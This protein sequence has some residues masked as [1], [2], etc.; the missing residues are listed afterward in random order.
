MNDP[1]ITVD[2]PGAAGMTCG[3]PSGPVYRPDW[4]GAGATLLLAPRARPSYLA[5][6]SSARLEDHPESERL[7][8]LRVDQRMLRGLQIVPGQHPGEIGTAGLKQRPETHLKRLFDRRARMEVPVL[9]LPP[10]HRIVGI[11]GIMLSEPPGCAVVV[12][13]PVEVVHEKPPARAEQPGE[14]R[15]NGIQL[16]VVERHD[17]DD[18]IEGAD[19]LNILGRFPD[20]VWLNGSARVHA[21]RIEA[22]FPQTVNQAAVTTANVED[23]R[24]RGKG[25]RDGRVEILPPAGVSHTPKITAASSGTSA[26]RW[27]APVPEGHG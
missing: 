16:G 22:K 18:R 27:I 14:C 19:A 23:S 11:R 4:L 9:A 8:H 6:S 15:G 20:Q 13:M 5:H 2:V 21:E 24:A 7:E 10:G 17:G 12:G 25:R 26:D 3:S 1:I